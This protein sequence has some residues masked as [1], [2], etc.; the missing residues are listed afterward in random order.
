MKDDLREEYLR[1]LDS[2]LTSWEKALRLAEDNG[3]GAG[4]D[5]STAYGFL[6]RAE[7]TIES[8]SGARSTYAKW[9]QTALEE[10]GGKSWKA[11]AAMGIVEA[12]RDD[13]ATGY[14]RSVSGVIYGQVF[15]DFL[16]MADYLL[17]EG[18]KDAAA[19]IAGGALESFL[20]QLCER[21]EVETEYLRPGQESRPKKASQ[22]NQDLGNKAY[23]LYDQKSVTAWLDLR[24]S[25]AHGKYEDYDE[26]QISLMIEGIRDFVKRHAA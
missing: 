1:H 7:N 23:S 5:E 13:V 25:G 20:R 14:L 26:N 19:V 10:A 11:E 8:I 22:L 16:D 3:L 2:L 9:L 24:N 15:G 4:L 18:Y 21:Y 17:R 12:L 6:A